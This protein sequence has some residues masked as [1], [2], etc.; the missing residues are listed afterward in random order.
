MN[1]FSDSNNMQLIVDNTLCPAEP[2]SNRKEESRGAQ[3]KENKIKYI[4]MRF[5]IES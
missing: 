3:W 5:E 1:W 2:T 4:G